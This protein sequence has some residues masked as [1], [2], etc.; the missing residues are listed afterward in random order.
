VGEGEASV[1]MGRVREV[2][3]RRLDVLLLAVEPALP[4]EV[5]ARYQEE[6]DLGALARQGVIPLDLGRAFGD[7]SG[8]ATPQGLRPQ[9]ASQDR[10]C[11]WSAP[12]VEVNVA[13]ELTNL[14]NLWLQAGVKLGVECKYANDKV[15]LS[16]S[17]TLTLGAG[18]FVFRP[19]RFAA[20]SAVGLG[21]EAKLTLKGSVDPQE[22]GSGYRW[23]FNGAIPLFTVGAFDV[24]LEYG[25]PAF[26]LLRIMPDPGNMPQADLVAFGARADGSLSL[27][28]D[29]GQ[30]PALSATPSV[31]FQFFLETPFQQLAFDPATRSLNLTLNGD[32]F[33]FG[34]TLGVGGTILKTLKPLLLLVGI[35][36]GRD[37][38]LGEDSLIG[39]AIHLHPLSTELGY[40]YV[41][42]LGALGGAEPGSLQ[43]GAA[44]KAKVAVR[45]PILQYLAQRNRLIASILAGVDLTVLRYTRLEGEHRVL[46]GRLEVLPG[47][48]QVR[49][50]GEYL[51]RGGA[52]ANEVRA[53]RLGDRSL[54]ATAPLR[55]SDRQFELQVPVPGNCEALPQEDRTAVVVLHA[56][57]AGIPV[58]LGWTHLGQV[59]LCSPIALEVPA[60]RAFVGETAQGQGT[61]RNGG[62]REGTLGLAA[63][64]VAVSPASLSQPAGGSD[65]FSVRYRC[66]VVGCLVGAVA[67]LVEG[68][69]VAGAPAVVT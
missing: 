4:W 23:L 9:S 57:L 54:L 16:P 63:E 29:T 37:I 7:R 69:T 52:E 5:Y 55:G 31:N 14:P 34:P 39:L 18:R 58:P 59:D 26:S 35:L 25:I 17:L 22:M 12:E 11:E 8:A 3:A 65:P 36:T 41:F 61:A 24:N 62:G 67:A 68:R 45:S 60:L 64:V 46:P 42:L 21:L 56:R 20:E 1:L 33:A 6:V 40:R 50:R 27:R 44:L 38:R 19:E 10:R 66:E 43:S 53:Y 2:V 49:L 47:G 48:G 32:L 15:V 28:Y 30:S 51:V 13:G